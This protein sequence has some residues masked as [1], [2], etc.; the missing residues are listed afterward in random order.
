MAINDS[1]RI[2]M[3]IPDAAKD[4]HLHGELIVEWSGP[5]S[6]YSSQRNAN[7]NY[8]ATIFALILTDAPVSL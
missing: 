3:H 8:Y 1:I 7:G 6:V 4:Q 5:H 2:G